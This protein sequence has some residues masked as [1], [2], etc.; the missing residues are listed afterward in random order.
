MGKHSFQKYAEKI[1]EES[2]ALERKILARIVGVTF[3]G[4]Q[5]FLAKMGEDTALRL[6]RD[7]RNPYDFHAVKVMA[8]L[9]G[10]WEHVGFVP[11]KMNK[12]VTKSL[13][14]GN[15]LSAC[16]HRITGGMYSESREE[17]LNYGLEIFII[18]E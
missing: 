6:E 17:T 13:D 2:S 4:R 1:R 7:R 10:A 12:K 9:D 18:P 5:E 11:K 15:P 14:N 16:V 3:D 8:Q